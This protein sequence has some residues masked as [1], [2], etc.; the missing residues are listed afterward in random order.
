[1][2]W[3]RTYS[4]PAYRFDSSTF[5]ALEP[6]PRGLMVPYL[7]YLHKAFGKPFTVVGDGT[8]TR[9]FTYVT[10]VVEAFIK[11]PSPQ[12]TEKL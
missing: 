2:H 7:A 10:D 8:Q 4:C 1:M 5:M 3:A 6:A 11:R 9:D 12:P